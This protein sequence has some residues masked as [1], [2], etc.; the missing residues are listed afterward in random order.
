K[1]AV[2]LWIFGTLLFLCGAS[3]FAAPA[4]AQYIF[5][6][7]NGDAVCNA[8]DVLQNGA[9]SVDVWL[10]TNHGA[11]GGV[12][13]CSNPTQPLDMFGYSVIFHAAGNGT[14]TYNT[15]TNA[16]AGFEQLNGLAVVGSEAG[17]DFSAPP[18]THVAP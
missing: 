5:M 2:R 12:T 4:Y 15:W 8:N 14:V 9:N 7:T 11:N 1:L 10:D 17:M 13:T 6:D 18:G 16:M 3:P